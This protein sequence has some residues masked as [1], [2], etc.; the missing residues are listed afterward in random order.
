MSAPFVKKEGGGR[1]A[2]KHYIVSAGLREI[3]D[4]TSIKSQFARIYASE[5]HF[6]HHDKATFPK[7][8]I[9]DTAKTQYLFR[10]NKGKEDLA[11]SINGHMPES[12]RPIPFSNIIYIG[13]GM[14]DV[15]S[16]TVTKSSGGNTIAVYK[17]N[18]RKGKDICKNLLEVGRVHFIAQADYSAGSDL[19]KRVKILLQSI[20]ANIEYQRELFDCRRAHGMAR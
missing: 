20:I 15:P 3:L 5:Y 1:I 9:T 10:I 11:E 14:T 8:L 17:K 13:D 6:D 2:I 4:G 12:L 18:S 16:M 7:V 19:D